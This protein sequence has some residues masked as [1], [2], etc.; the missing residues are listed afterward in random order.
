LIYTHGDPS[1]P[2][3]GHEPVK[4]E[5]IK[6][7]LEKLGYPSEIITHMPYTWDEG[8]QKLDDLFVY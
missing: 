8:L 5:S 7:A 2:M 1:D 6:K 3:H 4:T